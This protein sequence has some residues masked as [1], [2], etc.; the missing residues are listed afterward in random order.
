[1][2]Q[3]ITNQGF[4]LIELLVV[5]AIIGILSTLAIVALGSA[6][7]KSRDAKRVADLN[8]IGKALEL[9]YSDNN[10]YP[11]IIT[12]G[13]PISFGSTTYL[14]QVPSNPTPRNDGSCGNNNYIYEG[15]LTGN[16]YTISTCLSSATG[17]I[18]AGAVFISSA[19]GSGVT[20]CGGIITDRDGFSYRT[21]QIGTQCWMADNLR[22]KTKPDGAC[23]NS[24]CISGYNSS[25]RDC[26]GAGDV[27]GTEADCMAG[28]AVYTWSGAMNGSTTE[29]A[30]GMCPTG[31][32]IPSDAEQDTLEQYLKN[33]GQTCNASRTAYDCVG[34]GTKMMIGG[35]SGFNALL[36][37][38]RRTGGTTFEYQGLS[39]D[40]W[41]STLSGAVAYNRFFITSH[42]SG[43]D[44]Y[45]GADSQAYGQSVRCLKNL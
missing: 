15:S 4:T 13:Q 36:V 8:Q 43:S 33:T 35:S 11:T 28:Y 16:G 9:Y 3:K 24:P 22:T 37:G 30:Q 27:R 12:S 40:Y 10:S 25:P 44:I 31:W 1:M 32:H 21:A 45:R 38:Q 17:S 42:A 7:Q 39:F 26:V 20:P 2:K 5:I 19:G 18:S 6:R 41:S 14:A 34:A 29:G 23:I